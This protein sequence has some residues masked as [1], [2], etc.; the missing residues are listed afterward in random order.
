MYHGWIN[1]SNTTAERVAEIFEE[2][3]VVIKA[4]NGPGD[5]LVEVSDD[6]M[7]KLD[8]HWGEVVYGLHHCGP[9]VTPV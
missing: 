1:T 6:G 8:R 2:G 4:T 7:I 5:Y 9:G 3:D